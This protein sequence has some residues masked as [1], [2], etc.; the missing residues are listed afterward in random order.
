MR[1]LTI[2]IHPTEAS[3]VVVALAVG[4]L[5]YF[6]VIGSWGN[7]VFSLLVV[8]FLLVIVWHW[9]DRRRG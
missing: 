5:A 6:G 9:A 4:M 8:G 3:I 2:G 7:T 1:R